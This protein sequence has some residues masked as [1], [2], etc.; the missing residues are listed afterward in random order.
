MTSS[1]LLRPGT[2]AAAV[3]SE[4]ISEDLRGSPRP[5]AV[6]QDSRQEA[7]RQ[8]LWALGPLQK[9]FALREGSSRGWEAGSGVGA[10]RRL[11][12]QEGLPSFTGGAFKK[13][14]TLSLSDSLSRA[15]GRR[16]EQRD[17]VPNLSKNKRAQP[18]LPWLV[19]RVLPS[20]LPAVARHELQ[21]QAIL[22][23][24]DKKA[25]RLDIWGLLST[26]RRFSDCSKA[27]GG[28]GGVKLAAS[29][30]GEGTN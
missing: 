12:R 8:G 21:D 30:A 6:V 9:P 28:G 13:R 2:P 27:A 19:F 23:Q 5:R 3:G 1:Q 17:F 29:S 22:H 18:R 14:E 7:G 15:L 16:V 4:R 10:G 20:C 11:T 26:A 25:L 24:A